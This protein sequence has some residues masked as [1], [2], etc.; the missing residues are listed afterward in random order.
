MIDRFAN[1]VFHGD[2]LALL[3]VIPT[4]SMDAVIADAMYGTAKNCRYDWGPD[5]AKGNPVLHWQYHEP[6]YRECLRVL[7]RGGVLAWGQGA[8]FYDH[9]PAWFGGHRVWPLTRFS[10]GGVLAVGNIWVV[11]NR[12]QQPI[13]FPHKD[14][15]VICSRATHAAHKEHH[16]CPKPVEEMAWLIETLTQPGQIILDCFCGLGS[17]LVAAEQLG[18]RWIGC[19]RSK[20]YCQIALKRLSNIKNGRLIGQPA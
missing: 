9:F 15:L 17:T 20:R 19:D 4:A 18:R 7:K 13:E 16:P 1:K 11:Q 14:S 12:E 8:K 2:A 3:K 5:P 10:K 6:I